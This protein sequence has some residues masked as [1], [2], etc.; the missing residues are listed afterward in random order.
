MSNKQQASITACHLQQHNLS[1]VIDIG[2]PLTSY[3]LSS[4]T[5]LFVLFFPFCVVPHRTL[6]YSTGT[7]Q[8]AAL[9][10]RDIIN[11]IIIDI[12]DIGTA[13]HFFSF[14]VRVV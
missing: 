1:L 13:L 12:I 14:I 8:R 6:P 5:A 9:D 10:A 7:A 2:T 11:I 3:N 4:T